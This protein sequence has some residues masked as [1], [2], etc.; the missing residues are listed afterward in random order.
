MGVSVAY[1]CS[2]SV[3]EKCLRLAENDITGALLGACHAVNEAVPALSFVY[4]A[5]VCDRKVDFI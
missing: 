5:N 3:R 2:L 1:R 4:A